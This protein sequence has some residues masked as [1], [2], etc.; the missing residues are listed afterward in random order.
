MI[1]FIDFFASRQERFLLLAFRI[2]NV[3]EAN[4]QVPWISRSCAALSLV[5][6]FMS[7]RQLGKYYSTRAVDLAEQVQDVIA[8]AQAHHAAAHHSWLSSD[9]DRALEHG[10][11]ALAALGEDG[12]SVSARQQCGWLLRC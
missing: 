3:A 12:A 9:W 4:A 6:D 10:E 2:L 5:F 7:V 11:R 8:L 1:S